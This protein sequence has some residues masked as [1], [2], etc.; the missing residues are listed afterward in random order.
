[1][2]GIRV[3]LVPPEGENVEIQFLRF[4]PHSKHSAALRWC[5]SVAFTALIDRL[6]CFLPK[7]S[8]LDTASGIFVLVVA[9]KQPNPGCDENVAAGAKGLKINSC[10]WIFWCQ[11]H[12]FERMTPPDV[13]KV[14]KSGFSKTTLDCH[15]NPLVPELLKCQISLKMTYIYLY[16]IAVIRLFIGQSP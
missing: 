5:I 11:I 14:I 3:F 6:G 2:D 4:W 13:G 7:L 1:M 12:F 16:R 8:N 9:F 15:L 10:I